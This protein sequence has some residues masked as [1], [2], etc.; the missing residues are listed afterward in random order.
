MSSWVPGVRV[1]PGLALLLLASALGVGQT[2]CDGETWE[3]VNED[4]SCLQDVLDEAACL[5]REYCTLEPACRAM[6]CVSRADTDAACNALGVCAWNN[7][8]M[9]GPVGCGFSSSWT[10][11]QYVDTES[12]CAQAHRLRMGTRV[13][14]EAARL[15]QRRRP[16]HV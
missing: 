11:C 7:E 13:H 4:V 14:G 16:S 5:Q 1:I 2:G 12:A 9:Y 8:P 15:R 3:C 10:Q 6:T